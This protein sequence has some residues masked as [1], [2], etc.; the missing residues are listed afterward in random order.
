MNQVI[1]FV[2]QVLLTSEYSFTVTFA[3]LIVC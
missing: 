1:I 2:G 3:G